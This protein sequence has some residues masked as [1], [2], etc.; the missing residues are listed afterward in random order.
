MQIIVE[1]TA[2]DVARR[3]AEK[4]AAYIREN[5]GRLLCLAAGE[6]T[7]ELYGIL[8]DMHIQGQVDLNR[9]YYVMM[10]EW[11][12]ID[13][14]ANGSCAQIMNSGLYRRAG[15]NPAR[16][17]IWDGN[18]TDMQAE[19]ERVERGIKERGGIGLAVLGVGY[20]GHLGFNEPGTPADSRCHVA[21]LDDITVETGKRYF[22]GK[23]P[24][25][26]GVTVGLR[27]LLGAENILL[28]ALGAEKAPIMRRALMEEPTLQC[29]ASLL[30]PLETFQVLMD[31]ALFAAL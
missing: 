22:D 7:Q 11:V 18:A 19:C 24:P 8:S 25:N 30:Q 26:R 16:C 29:P 5:P 12:G 23:T 20:N 15:I 10:D 14:E 31:R 27:R 3:A 21:E 13:A 17:L 2:A 6:T 1:A 4:T 28:M 9:M